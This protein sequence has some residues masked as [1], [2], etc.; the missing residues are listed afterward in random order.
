[1]TQVE[2][3]SLLIEVL[4]LL[5]AALALGT[6][7]EQLRQS[8]IVGYLIAGALVGPNVLGLVKSQHSVEAIADLGVALLLFSIGL[9]F[10]FSRLKRLGWMVLFQGIFQ[11]VFTCCV[12]MIVGMWFGLAADTSF[13]LGTM[14]ALSSTACVLRLLTDR[15]EV[16]SPHGRSAMGI[17]L[18]QDAAVLPLTLVIAAMAGGGTTSQVIFSLGRTML[19][20][21]WMAACFLVLFNWIV[22]RLL[23]MRLWATNREFPVLLAIVMAIGSAVA[24]H[25]VGVSP[26]MGAFL[27][28]MLLAESPFAVQVRADVGPLKTALVTLFFV[29]IGM[30]SDPVWVGHH[31]QLVSIV[32]AGVVFGNILIVWLLFLAL[33]VPSSVGIAAGLCLAQIGEFSFVLARIARGPLIDEEM[34]KLVVSVTVITLFMTP[35]LVRLAPVLGGWIERR[36]RKQVVPDEREAKKTPTARAHRPHVIIVGFGPAGQRVAE[37][38]VSLYAKRILVIDLNPR[39]VAIARQRGVAMH[40]GNAGQAEVLE[41]AK[42]HRAAAVVIT[43]PDPAASRQVIH[44]CRHMNPGAKIIA[45]ARYHAYRW[46]LM[47][48]GAEVVVDEEEQVGQ[49][50]AAEVRL[51][52]RTGDKTEP[53]AAAEA[54]LPVQPASDATPSLSAVDETV[55]STPVAPPAARAA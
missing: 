29:S 26:A 15:A 11:I 36:G 41:A 27:A 3:W 5:T 33:R 4:I 2:Q 7:A 44:L 28:G 22:P 16:E 13:A 55:S 47:A 23:N 12:V 17:L 18:L 19:F 1:M 43:L 35:Y 49:R 9:E 52:V 48:A 50:L 30:L 24:A 54:V 53:A 39:A 21:G 42:I 45:R 51:A 38:L 20:A 14:A 32:T 10:S 40:V 6:V 25:E 34:L 31:W 8:A 37:S 46:E